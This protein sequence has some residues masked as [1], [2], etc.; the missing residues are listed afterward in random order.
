MQLFEFEN[1]KTFLNS[2]QHMGQVFAPTSQG[3][4]AKSPKTHA[5]SMVF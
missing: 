2:G 5:E 4:R 1:L 3:Q